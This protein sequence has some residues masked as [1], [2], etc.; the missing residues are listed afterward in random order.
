MPYQGRR[1]E[2]KASQG[3]I[4][5]RVGPTYLEAEEAARAIIKAGFPSSEGPTALA[6]MK[7]ESWLSPDAQGD[8]LIQDEEWGP[9]YGLLQIR[10]RK[11]KANGR[12][13]SKL[14]DVAYN[15]EQAHSLFL[16][17]GWR[18]WG[19]FTSGRYRKHLAWAEDVFAL[20]GESWT[21]GPS[22][23]STPSETLPPKEPQ[24]TA[25]AA[26][27]A[28]ARGWGAPCSGRTVTVSRPD[29]VRLPVRTEIAKLVALLCAET[30]RLGYNLRPGE[31][32]GYACRKIRGSSTWSNHAWGLAVDLNAPENPMGPR[33]GK[34]R[35]YPKVIAL[36]KSY[37][38]RWGGDYSGRADDMH[39]E[40]VGTP[41][42]AKRF[43]T[44]AEQELENDMTPEQ[45]ER[46]K[47]VEKAVFS[48]RGEKVYETTTILENM[49]KAIGAKAG[50]SFNPDGTAQ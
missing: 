13:A 44:Q 27:G 40:F 25:T 12:D 50:V 18:P 15:L 36:W 11:D 42:D 14:K 41:S 6:V 7:E 20:L 8:L 33:N 17:S 37:G 48:K 45:D 10:S 31:C 21:T 34:I 28:D 38:F 29:G 3:R 43:T 26:M 47:A 24:T 5:G 19:A 4:A 30:E 16:V 22:K 35:Q 23:T 32:W 39:M 49:L 46:L 1:I 2:F 9:S